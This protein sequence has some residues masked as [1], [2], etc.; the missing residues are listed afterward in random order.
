MHTLFRQRQCK[1]YRR[2]NQPG[3][4]PKNAARAWNCPI[5]ARFVDPDEQSPAGWMW[6]WALGRFAAS[7]RA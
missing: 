2:A 7:S 4:D 1:K 6:R 3:D 5:V